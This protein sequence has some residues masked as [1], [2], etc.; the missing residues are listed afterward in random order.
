MESRNELSRITIDI[1]KAEHK[2]LKAMSALEGKSMREIVIESIELYIYRSNKPNK[3][4]IKALK[5]AEKGKGLVRAKDFKD[6]LKKMG[7]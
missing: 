4:T 3:T 2:R 7:I 5:D 6:L 1:P